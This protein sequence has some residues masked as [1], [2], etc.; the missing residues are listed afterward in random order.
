MWLAILKVT[1]QETLSWNLSR[2]CSCVMYCQNCNYCNSAGT[3][4][5]SSQKIWKSP[6]TS[7][8]VHP[9]LKLLPPVYSSYKKCTRNGNWSFFLW[10]EVDLYETYEGS[11]LHMS[12]HLLWWVLDS[13]LKMQNIFSVI[14]HLISGHFLY[15]EATAIGLINEKAHVKSSLWKESSGTCV[16]SFW[17]FKS[18]KA[19]GH[20]QVLIKVIKK[21]FSFEYIIPVRVF[22]LLKSVQHCD[23]LLFSW[24]TGRAPTHLLVPCWFLL[25]QPLKNASSISLPR[26]V[27]LKR[28]RK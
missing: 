7:T 2:C 25:L 5:Q 19:M 26:E 4:N 17:Y 23:I 20:I 18:S 28:K 14:R 8:Q 12:L 22:M 10:A 1:F 21:P 15:L 27:S 3:Y 11:V 16:M 13:N 6:Q 9:N 24:Q